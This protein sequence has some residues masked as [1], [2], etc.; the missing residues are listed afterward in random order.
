MTDKSCPKR[1]RLV[2]RLARALNKKKH[3]DAEHSVPEK[4]AADQELKDAME[5]VRTNSA[6]D[7]CGSHGGDKEGERAA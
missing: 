3:S 5:A 1:V 6:E 4:V 7:L 2:E